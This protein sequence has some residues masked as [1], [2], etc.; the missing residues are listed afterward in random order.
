MPQKNDYSFMCTGTRNTCEATDTKLLAHVQAATMVFL[1][2]AM[3]FGHFLHCC[4]LFNGGDEAKS[5]QYS[6]K[7]AILALKV[8]A[9]TGMAIEGSKK[10]RIQR[11]ANAVERYG[12]PDDVLDH[13]GDIVQETCDEMQPRY[14]HIEKQVQALTTAQRSKVMAQATNRAE[15][16]EAWMP[17]D[18]MS[19][20]IKSTIKVLADAM[21]IDDD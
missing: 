14:D 13:I 6:K 19:L 16:Y 5:D 10:E 20:A 9:T 17:Q 1:D 21:S 8:K 3:A 18:P 12:G 4:W 2:E 11:Y 7:H 15:E